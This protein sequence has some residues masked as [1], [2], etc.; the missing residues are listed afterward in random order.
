M[1]VGVD[2]EGVLVVGGEHVALLADDR[3][4]DDLAGVHYSVASSSA[5]AGSRRRAASSF[6]PLARLVSS[7]SGLLGDQQRGGAD[8]VGDA[9]VARRQ[10]RDAAQV[11]ERQRHVGLVLGE[12]DQHRAAAGPLGDELVGLLGRG[13]VEGRRV[14]D[15]DRA[16]VGVRAQ[17]AAQ[18]GAALLAVDLEGVVARVGAEDDAAAGPDRR[19]RRAGAGAAGALLAPRLGAAAADV[20][21]RLGRRGALAAGVELRAHGLVD[22]RAVEARAEGDV[23]ELD[24]LRL[25]RAED[26]G[27]SHRY[28]PP[29]RRCAGP[30]R[31]R[32]RAAG[33]C[34]RPRA[35]PRG[36]SGSRACCPSGPGRGCP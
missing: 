27:V 15:R 24:R 7:S 28:A 25:R 26:R 34:R 3:A 17:R 23:V 2:A 22:E 19:A 11:A 8:E 18:R 16:A 12:D 29:P 13:R 10:H 4:D 36:P 6:S 14:E 9:A 33:C 32:A 1:R 5:A 21:A 30:A 35:R 20:A 31:S